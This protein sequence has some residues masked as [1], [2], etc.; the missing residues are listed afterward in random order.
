MGAKRFVHPRVGL[1]VLDYE[2]LVVPEPVQTLIVYS[3]PVD[4]PGQGALELLGALSS[5]R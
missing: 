3:A 5:A 4:S 1:I 2:T